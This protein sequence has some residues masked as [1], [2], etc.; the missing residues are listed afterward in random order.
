MLSDKEFDG[1]QRLEVLRT[2]FGDDVEAT[3]GVM[4]SLATDAD[5]EHSRD[6]DSCHCIYTVALTVAS[7]KH[8]KEYVKKQSLSQDSGQDSDIPDRLPGSGLSL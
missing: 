1:D 8:C 6:V 2:L 5:A 3:E 7:K 4:A